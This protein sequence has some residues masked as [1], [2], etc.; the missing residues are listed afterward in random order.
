MQLVM[1]AATQWFL[2]FDAVDKLFLLGQHLIPSLVLILSWLKSLIVIQSPLLTS[3]LALCIFS[4]FCLVMLGQRYTT[5]MVTVVCPVTKLRHIASL[6]SASSRNCT[7]YAGI[8]SLMYSYTPP[9]F[10]LFCL[11]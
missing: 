4:L 2:Y 11:S 1:I 9:P 5:P 8:V 7:P 6:Q 10:F 3:L